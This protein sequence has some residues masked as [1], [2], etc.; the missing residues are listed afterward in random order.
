MT[1]VVGPSSC[2]WPS[3][4]VGYGPVNKSVTKMCKRYRVCYMDQLSSNNVILKLRILI[5]Q[6]GISFKDIFFCYLDYSYS[7]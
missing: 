4:A 2:W 6:N 7:Q 3:G 5:P 1:C